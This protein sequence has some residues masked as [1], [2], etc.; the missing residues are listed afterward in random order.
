MANTS[1]F[2]LGASIWTNDIKNITTAID[3]VR[4]GILW[5]NK[6]SRIPPE[7]PFGGDKESGTGR[8]NG[9]NA[10]EQYLMEKT[11]IIAP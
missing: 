8:E 5:V 4:S 6:H 10:L 11:I 2:G 9:L 7:V 3:E 1:K